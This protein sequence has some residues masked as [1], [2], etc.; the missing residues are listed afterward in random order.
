MRLLI[1]ANGEKYIGS[2]KN[3]YHD[4]AG[5]VFAVD[6]QTLR[7][8]GFGYD[9]EGPDAFFV[10]G[11]TDEEPGKGDNT[12]LPHPFDGK[13]YDYEDKSVPILGKFEGVSWRVVWLFA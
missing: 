6:E 3:H 13:F 4:I 10:V 5:K 12:I 7:I 1:S 9:G 8:E 11:T 2:F